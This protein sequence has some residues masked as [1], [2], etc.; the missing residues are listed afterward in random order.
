MNE[1]R[2]ELTNGWH[3]VGWHKIGKKFCWVVCADSHPTAHYK[4]MGDDNIYAYQDAVRFAGKI[5]PA[6]FTQMMAD[7]NSGALPV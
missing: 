7:Y 4:A 5:T 6:D 2:I 1:Q 3:I